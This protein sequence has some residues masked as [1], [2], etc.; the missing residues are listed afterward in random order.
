MN[1]KYI[2]SGIVGCILLSFT[3]AFSS[4]IIKPTINDP[5]FKAVYIW[6]PAHQSALCASSSGTFCM[7]QV[8]FYRNEIPWANSNILKWNNWKITIGGLT[9]ADIPDNIINS[10]HIFNTTILPGDF[11]IN[12][13]NFRIPTAGEFARTT[14][15]CW[16]GRAAT[17]MNA[18]V[19]RC[20]SV[21]FLTGLALPN[22]GPM[23]SWYTLTFTGNQWV[24]LSNVV[25]VLWA[26]IGDTN[27][28]WATTW[29]IRNKNIGNVWVGLTNATEKLTIKDS[30]AVNWW[31][32]GSTPDLIYCYKTD[33]WVDKSSYVEDDCILCPSG[34]TYDW[35]K[36]KCTKPISCTV[37]P[38]NAACGTA[39]WSAYF[40]APSTNLCQDGSAP[41]RTAG[42]NGIWTWTCLGANGGTNASCQ[43]KETPLCGTANGKSYVQG[44][45]IYD[46]YCTR[47]SS[48]LTGA[49]STSSTWTKSWSCSQYN[50]TDSCSLTV[51]APAAINWACGTATWSAYF[52]SPT[53]NLCQDG[54]TPARSAGANGTWTWTCLGANG[55]TNASCTSKETPLCGTANGKSITQSGALPGTYC[56][57]WLPTPSSISTTTVWTKSWSCSQYNATG[58]CSL[59]VTAPA[60]VDGYC[61]T[62]TTSQARENKPAVYQQCYAWSPGPIWWTNPRTWSCY[63]QYG[64]TNASCQS[65]ETPLCGT[66]NGKS[67]VQGSTIYDAYCTRWSSNLTG[68]ISTSSTWTK[69]WSC[70]QYN[71]T[72]SCSLTVTAPA[73][74]NWACGTA[75]WSAYFTAPSTNLCISGSPSTR[76]AGTNGTWTWTCLGANGGTNASCQSKE[77][78]LCGTANGKSITQSGA[79]P[80]TYCTRWLPTPSSISTTTVWTKSWSCSQYNAT[81]SCSL[82]VTAPAPVDGYC[83]TSTTSQARENKPAVYQ[84]CYAWSPGPIWWINPRTWSCYGQYGGT[85]ASCSTMPLTYHR[86]TWSWGVCNAGYRYRTVTCKDNFNR[87]TNENNCTA[88]K[89][90]TYEICGTTGVCGSSNWLYISSSPTTNLCNSGNP[91][92][93]TTTYSWATPLSWSWYCVSQDGGNSSPECVSYRWN[94]CKAPRDTNTSYDHGVIITAYSNSSPNC[95][96]SC[97]P[98]TLTCNNWTWIWADVATYNKAYCSAKPC[99]WIDRIDVAYKCWDSISCPAWYFNKIVSN[100]FFVVCGNT[101]ITEC[102]KASTPIPMTVNSSKCLQYP[103]D[104]NGSINQWNFLRGTF[105]EGDSSNPTGR[106]GWLNSTNWP[107][108]LPYPSVNGSV[109]CYRS[110]YSDWTIGTVNCY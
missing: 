34:Y 33:T 40:T 75:T 32:G 110:I 30:L 3:T 4:T 43:S 95:W 63:G 12:Y 102:Y 26:D 66:A 19:M 20:V 82:T 8:G 23:G 53:T 90:L 79:L 45:T 5:V 69:S 71:A 74:I 80:G 7:D 105:I 78:P 49:I 107:V 35:E 29:D 48:N 50:A 1:K 72:D 101:R 22:C 103:A 25:N 47:W 39:T 15:N 37:I 2:I 61:N 31:G 77:T 94:P 85:N 62:S 58:S 70:S 51:T 59:T 11:D 42:A 36:K 83:N 57:R 56:T 28:S 104:V 89:P 84:Q 109:W 16:P 91:S 76:T 41:T 65:K 67:Y 97:D 24:C 93:I 88:P 98:K 73:A 96:Y 64:G 46:A 10:T 13:L 9:T 44:S 81:G 14:G 99:S 55:G 87:D 86:D 92:P 17:G 108:V 38:A 21:D 106:C 68:A 52:T 60:P 6:W 54:S 100:E 27:W 18:W